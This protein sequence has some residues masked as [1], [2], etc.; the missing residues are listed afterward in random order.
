MSVWELQSLPILGLQIWSFWP[1]IKKS[2]CSSASD[3]LQS[4]SSED[5]EQGLQVVCKLPFLLDRVVSFTA[6]V[7]FSVAA[8]PCLCS[9]HVTEMEKYKP[10]FQWVQMA[11]SLV[12]ISMNSWTTYFDTG[13]SKLRGVLFV[14]LVGVVWFGLVSGFFSRSLPSSQHWWDTSGVLGPVL[15]SPVWDRQGHTGPS[16]VRSQDDG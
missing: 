15:G 7:V 14:W 13:K 10:T 8:P 2:F 11:V 12:N 3:V 1:E 4:L 9:A 5:T 16:P 6:Y